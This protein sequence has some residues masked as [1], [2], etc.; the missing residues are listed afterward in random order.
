MKELNFYWQ[1]LKD[2]FEESWLSNVMMSWAGSLRFSANL[3]T[4]QALNK[5]TWSYLNFV[6][7]EF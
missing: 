5:F 4:L 2:D 6:H 3:I 7:F 1:N